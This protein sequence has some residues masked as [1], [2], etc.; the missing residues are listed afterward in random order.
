MTIKELSQ[1]LRISEQA[2]RQWCK[3]NNVRNERTQAKQRKQRK[4]RIDETAP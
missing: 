3:K 2:L 4:Q 1:D